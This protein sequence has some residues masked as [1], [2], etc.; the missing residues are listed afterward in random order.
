M[1]A[2]FVVAVG[3]DSL[4][5]QFLCMCHLAAGQAFLIHLA[6]FFRQLKETFG[7]HEAGLHCHLI[8][9]KTLAERL[10]HSIGTFVDIDFVCLDFFRGLVGNGNVIAVAHGE[11]IEC[12]GWQLRW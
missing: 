3:G 12:H 7:E 6:V 2:Q 10:D 4:G 11:P 5:E 1:G 8:A 9:G